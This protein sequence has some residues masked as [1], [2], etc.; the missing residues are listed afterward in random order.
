MRPY[1]FRASLVLSLTSVPAIPLAA[2][3]RV[4]NGRHTRLQRFARDMAYGTAE[5]LVFAGLDQAMSRPSEWG[6]GIN[7][8]E[9]RAASNVGEFAIQEG[10]TEGLAAALKHSLDYTRCRCRGTV[11]R[12]GHALLGTV[13]DEAPGGAYSLAIPRMAGAYAGAFAQASWRPG[14]SSNRV[15]VALRNGTTSLAF[16]A[17]INMFHEFVR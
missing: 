3:V 8:Y 10:V 15:Q 11:S 16:G 5:G 14:P 7:G 1:L 9:K 2:Q 13:A 6:T 17:L 12:I 4:D